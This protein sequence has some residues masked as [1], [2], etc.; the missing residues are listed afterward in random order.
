YDREVLE[1]SVGSVRGAQEQW[2]ET[3]LPIVAMK[4]IGRP[5]ILGDFQ[6]D[7][8]ELAVALGVIGVVA[9]APAVQTIAVEI[10]GVIDEEIAD[11]AGGAASHD[12][13]ETEPRTHR[14]GDTRDNNGIRFGAA[15]ARQ[16]D[17]DFV[18]VADQCFGK[19]F[20]D[21]RQTTGFGERQAFRGYE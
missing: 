9:T 14:N 5:E 2:D 19:T 21:V 17:R 12:R 1:R 16:D 3:G 13:G 7:T 15:I 4:D 18:T 11:A 10:F 8:A 20:D 6:R